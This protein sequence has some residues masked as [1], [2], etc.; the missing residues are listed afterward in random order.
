MSNDS[1]QKR[2]NNNFSQ[3][4]IFIVVIVFCEVDRCSA[5]IF[6]NNHF[7]FCSF[8]WILIIIIKQSY[9]ITCLITAH[10]ILTFLSIYLTYFDY[11][12]CIKSKIDFLLKSEMCW[13]HHTHTN[14]HL[15]PMEW[16]H[17]S[18]TKKTHKSRNLFNGE[19]KN[20][21]SSNDYDGFAKFANE[22]YSITVW[23]WIWDTG[24][25]EYN[26]NM[27][28]AKRTNKTER[29]RYEPEQKKVWIKKKKNSKETILNSQIMRYYDVMSNG[30]II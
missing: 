12:I 27:P 5:M 15:L 24:T 1:V 19:V 30:R 21:S 11:Y 4:R 2:F 8:F 18:R 17:R 25:F 20:L 14:T 29:E 7:I 22:T 9:I 26:D 10:C 16:M 23:H 28:L 6:Q 3:W 13:C